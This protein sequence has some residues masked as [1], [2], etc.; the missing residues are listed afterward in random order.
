MKPEQLPSYGQY[1]DGG[2]RIDLGHGYCAKVE[3]WYDECMREPWKEMDGCV[4]GIRT[5]STNYTGHISKSPNERILH[6]GDRNQWDYVYD[7]NASL[8]VA[9]KDGWGCRADLEGM[10]K[11]QRAVKAVEENADWLRRWLNNEWHWIGCTVTLYRTIK[12]DGH[13]RVFDKEHEVMTESCGG[14]E[15][16]GDY[17]KEMACELIGDA[18]ENDMEERRQAWRQALAEAREE[19]YWN[20]RDVI[21]EGV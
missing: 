15:D 16:E 1:F 3:L 11:K 17:W 4:V 7:F 18:V 6:K 20:Q 8:A 21:T 12:G 14:F 9:L 5:A 2:E 10:T 13:F 19:R